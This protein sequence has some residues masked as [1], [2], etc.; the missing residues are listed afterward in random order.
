MCAYVM[1]FIVPRKGNPNSHMVV[2][3]MIT[4]MVISGCRRLYSYLTTCRPT[5][6]S[7]NSLLLQKQKMES[8]SSLDAK[9]S[10]PSQ[11]LETAPV[12]LRIPS[13]FS[14]GTINTS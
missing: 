6:S 2:C 1:R 9:A 11:T 13:P 10:S 14:R 7:I 12:Y 3:V 4:S 5:C 8:E